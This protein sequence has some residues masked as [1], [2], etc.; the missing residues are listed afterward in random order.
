MKIHNE[1]LSIEV[2]GNKR[3]KKNQ[4]FPE[5]ERV[6]SFKHKVSNWLK[7]LKDVALG[8]EKTEDILRSEVRKVLDIPRKVAVSAG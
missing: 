6:F 2:N 3:K 8:E 7:D 4:W 1:Y 5:N